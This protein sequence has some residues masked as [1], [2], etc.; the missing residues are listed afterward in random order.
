M[1]S[2]RRFAELV[3]G[4]STIDNTHVL[5]RFTATFG[6]Q[7]YVGG[8]LSASV[9]LPT[10]YLS[11][12]RDDD[13]LRLSGTGDVDVGLRYNFAGIWGTGGYH[14]SLTL[15]LGLGL[16]TGDSLDEAS[17]TASDASVSLLS[18]GL[19]VF[20]AL[21]ELEYTQFLHRSVALTL[22]ASIK[23]PLTAKNTGFT[24]GTRLGYNLGL[25]TL[26]AT[27]LFLGAGVDGHY[28]TQGE[29]LHGGT[30]SKSGGHWLA[31]EAQV[32]YF[33]SK[34]L[35]IRV[36]GRLPF[37]AKVNDRQMSESFSV[38]TSL[39]W[40]FG[41]DDHDHGLQ[42]H[43][44]DEAPGHGHDHEAE[45]NSAPVESKSMLPEP[46]SVPVDP[47]PAPAEPTSESVEPEPAPIPV[48][49]TPAEPKPAADE[50]THKKHKHK[51]H[52]HKHK[53]HKHKHKRSSR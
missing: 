11:Y 22:R 26:P 24:Y 23:L 34:S 43:H 8:G 48:I 28:I 7:H 17:Q 40:R 36:L 51:K 13:D 53:K 5:E 44:E 45:P 41:G 39:V 31:A 1:F 10:G 21:A 46:T 30:L 4:T 14:P 25:L 47:K 16:P 35:T 42:H 29:E 19:G 33:L 9:M 27:S 38:A 18:L 12:E 20:S 6:I 32:G 52:K 49:S 37:Y 50:R 15:H 2:Y 3:E